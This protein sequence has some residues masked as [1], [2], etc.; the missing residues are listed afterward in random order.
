MCGAVLAAATLCATA[1]AGAV[2]AARGGS[3]IDQPISF[4]VS[5]LNRSGVAC[6]T[7]G[8][9]YTVRGHL[10]GPAAELNKSGPKSATLYLHGLELGEWFWRFDAV[11]KFDHAREMAKRGHVS[12]TIDRLGYNSSEQPPGMESCVGGQADVTHQIVQRLREGSYSG[13]DRT[14]VRF[15]RIA[16]VGHSL[17]GAITQVE[18]YSFRSVDAIAVLSFAD[19]AAT[20]EALGTT[21]IWGPICLRG[22]ESS[23]GG[24]PGYAYFTPSEASFQQN[25]LENAPPEVVAAATPLR[26][27]NPCGD[28]ESLAQTVLVDTLRLREITVPVLVLSGT[29]DRV[30]TADGVAR[31]GS[32]FSGSRDV[33]VHLLDGATHG[34]TLEPTAPEFRD[35]LSEWLNARGF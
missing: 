30:F 31:H 6:A 34:L 18:A 29:H 15:E 5:N 28:M 7:D 32:Q 33:T 9:E 12:I 8:S 26:D 23:A 4:Q 22:G 16:L 35:L 24:S 27:R 3:I 2:G 11:P 14:P 25:F 10:V 21:L 20:P 13:E 1:P 19:H 17:G